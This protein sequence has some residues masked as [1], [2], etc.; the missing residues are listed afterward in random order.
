MGRDWTD[1]NLVFPSLKGTPQHFDSLRKYRFKTLLRRAGLPTHFTLYSFRYTFA[2]LQMLGGQ[3][4]KVIADLM[5]H[6]RVD[7]NQEVYQKVLPR[8]REKASDTLENLL[9]EDSCTM[10]AQLASEREM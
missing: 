1:Y 7:F 5:G 10:F 3:R 6:T 2:T 9:F 8:M 4:D